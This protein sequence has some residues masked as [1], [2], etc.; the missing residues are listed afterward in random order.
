MYDFKGKSAVV[1]GAGRGNGAAMAEGLAR[2]GATVIVADVEQ[3]GAEAV[4]R[5]IRESGGSAHARQ[6]DV[7]DAAA[8]DRLGAEIETLDILI[9]NAGVL[10]RGAIEAEDAAAAWQR[11]LDVNIT[12]M[13]N[14][15]RALLP[16][17]TE[18]RGSI[19]NV[20]SMQSFIH[21][22]GTSPAYTASKGA[23]AAFTRA[24]AV[25]L[26]PQGIRVNAI[27]PGLIETA[28][29]E[30]SRRDN[31]ARAADL[32]KAIPLGRWGTPTDLIGPVC[33]LASEASG[34]VTGVVLP[35]DGGRLAC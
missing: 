2:L 26:A 11:T 8:C 3:E 1:T 16:A 33:F 9:N 12:G 30:T 29:N 31:P 25:D 28:M 5:H 4:A 24:M 23:V 27:A 18:A 13:F 20:A 35:V 32:A 34:Y 10:I 21:L 6:L 17:L 22:R 14:I 19:V 15:T 7:A